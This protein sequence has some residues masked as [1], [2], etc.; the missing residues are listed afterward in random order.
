MSVA[1]YA[2]QPPAIAVVFVVKVCVNLT[3][4]IS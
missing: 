3:K 2:E 1:M 4:E